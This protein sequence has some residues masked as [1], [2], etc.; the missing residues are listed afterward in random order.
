ME[1][2]LSIAD[3]EVGERCRKNYGDLQGLAH[4]IKKLGLLQ[5]I[6]VTKD[7]YKLLFGERRLKAVQLNGD[8]EIDCRILDIKDILEAEHAE[9]EFRLSLSLTEKHALAE[10]LQRQMPK[11]QG[12]GSGGRPKERAASGQNGH[13]RE[14]V[15]GDHVAAKAG[16]IGGRSE[17]RRVDKVMKSDVPELVEAMDKGE[18]PVST[19][20]RIADLP[21]TKERK[22]A[23]NAYKAN[24]KT[25]RVGKSQAVMLE[26]RMQEMVE[27]IRGIKVQHATADKMFASS[28]W[29]TSTPEEIRRCIQVTLRASEAL[30][31]L[32]GEMKKYAK[33]EEIHV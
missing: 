19:A 14:G 31:V 2:R 10:E 12:Q 20:A 13:K 11:R 8:T 5:A 15:T 25:A 26:E 23:L 28:L 30:A 27:R 9:N 17:M 3:I 22:E 1:K 32:A 6:G 24:P 7:G 4:S 21:T 18:V 29:A 33:K 16:F